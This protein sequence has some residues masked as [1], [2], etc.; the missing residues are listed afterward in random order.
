MRA[1]TFGSK[2][3]AWFARCSRWIEKASAAAKPP[4][5]FTAT[6]SSISGIGSSV[7]RAPASPSCLRAAPKRVPTVLSQSPSSMPCGTPSRRPPSGTA[8]SG[9]KSSPAITAS[10]LAQSATLRASGPIKSS[11]ND[12]GNAPSVGTRHALGLKPTMPHSAA[13]MRVEPPVS[14]P[15]AMSHMRSAAATAAPDEEP[16]GTR[17]RSAGLPGVP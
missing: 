14:V 17:A 10:A 13:G 16:P 8:S 15:I 7:T 6:M 2:S 12:N 9:T 3:C 4:L 1:R 5:A 11:E